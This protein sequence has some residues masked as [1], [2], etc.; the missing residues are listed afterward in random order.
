[1]RRSP[2]EPLSMQ[3]AQDI[4]RRTNGHAVL[5]GSLSRLGSEYVLSLNVLDCGST[6]VSTTR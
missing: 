1:M 2:E 4:C 6:R 5:G 3:I